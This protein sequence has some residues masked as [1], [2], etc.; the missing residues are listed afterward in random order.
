MQRKSAVPLL[1]ASFVFVDGVAFL[2][3]CP[4]RLQIRAGDREGLHLLS[5]AENAMFGCEWIIGGE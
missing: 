5:A 4:K 1:R 2:G 3:A